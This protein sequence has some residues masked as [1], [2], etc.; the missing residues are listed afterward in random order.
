MKGGEETYRADDVGVAMF[1]LDP[2][3]VLG[4]ASVSGL[5][6]PGADVGAAGR[7]PFGV[8]ALGQV[9]AVFPC[10]PDDF[11]AG[12]VGFGRG[13]QDRGDVPGG[14]APDAVRMFGHSGV[15]VV[16][17]AASLLVPDARSDGL[18]WSVGS[19]W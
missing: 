7:A 14:K 10:L 2:V 13:S 18:V 17:V 9:D 5:A 1:A 3:V 8:G 15:R 19:I 16:F 4:E 6:F 12:A 11:L